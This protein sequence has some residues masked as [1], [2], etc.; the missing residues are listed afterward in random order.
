V[1]FKQAVNWPSE[2]VLND[3]ASELPQLPNRA[4][5]F[6]HTIS[7][8]VRLH[9]DTVFDLSKMSSLEGAM[10]PGYPAIDP[11]LVA[12]SMPAYPLGNHSSDDVEM[13]AVKEEKPLLEERD[14][15]M[16]DLF[17]NDADVEEIGKTEG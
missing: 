12:E 17:G 1:L 5:P 8:R 16:A 3:F 14:E 10:A 4:T 7:V 9:S 11:A 15:E 6:Q 13:R 2:P